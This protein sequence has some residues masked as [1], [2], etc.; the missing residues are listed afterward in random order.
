M[1]VAFYPVGGPEEITKN[2]IPVI[3]AAG[4]AVLVRAHVESILVD[5]KNTA[6]GKLSL[7]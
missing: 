6:V 7:L 3:E 4:G 2:I 5:E 1:C